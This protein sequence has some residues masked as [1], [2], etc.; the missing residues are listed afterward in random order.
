MALLVPK[1]Y[2]KRA[3]ATAHNIASSSVHRFDSDDFVNVSD[4]QD[5]LDELQEYINS[6]REEDEN[7]HLPIASG[8][9]LNV[10]IMAVPEKTKGGLIIQDDARER[11]AVMSPQG[12][13]L[14]MGSACYT[15]T[16]RF[17]WSGELRPWHAVGDRILF[18]KYDAK[19]FRL[20]NGQFIGTLV[21]TD[22]LALIDKDWEI[23]Q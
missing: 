7:Y 6:R 18:P 15:D 22:P 13:V 4:V 2:N 9:K 21:E 10:L 17:G 1:S 14:S 5:Q 11:R 8:W 12:V 3:E 19:S 23:P 16:D 20:G